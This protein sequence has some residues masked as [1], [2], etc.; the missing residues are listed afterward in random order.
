MLITV[1]NSK[2]LSYS[3][4]KEYHDCPRKYKLNRIDGVP[5]PQTSALI[6]GSIVDEIIG[7]ILNKQPWDFGQICLKYMGQDMHFYKDDLDLDLLDLNYISEFAKSHGW[8]GDDIGSA[9]K[10]FMQDQENLSN[11]QRSVL[12]NAVWECLQIKIRAMVDSFQKWI[13]P[14][15]AEV[16]DIQTHVE[17]DKVHGY[18]DFT[19]TLK[20]GRKVLFDLKTSSRAYDQDAVLKSPQ[21]SLYAALH[22]YEY[23]GYIVLVKNLN[24]NKIK[25]CTPCGHEETGGNRVNCPK[26]KEKMEFTMEPTSFSQLIVNKVP[27][28]NKHLT[29]QAMYDTLNAIN[30]GIFPQ[31]LNSCFWMYGRECPYV[32]KC[33][34]GK[35]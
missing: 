14:Q 17:D 29:K 15:I 3:A 22:D 18:L 10:S 2:K 21:L 27:D 1:S 6:V 4:Y 34:K 26:C 9:L 31:N 20:D 12:Y 28:F 16:H 8:N 7:A 33:W 24:K 25:T 19:A 30:K 35:S 32:A 11:G 13:L 23:A 5:Q